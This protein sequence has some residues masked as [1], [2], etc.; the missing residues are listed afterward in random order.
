MLK[1]SSLKTMLA[2]IG[3]AA[4]TI[5]GAET[6]L[7]D[8]DGTGPDQPVQVQMWDFAPGNVLAK[9]G[10]TAASA[11]V[12]SPFQALG[13][14]QLIGLFNNGNAITTTR[15]N[16]DYEITQVVRYGETVESNNDLNSNS[17]PEYATFRFNSDPTVDNFFELW[18]SA[19]DA[20]ALAGTG[21]NNGTLILRGKVVNSYSS[22]FIVESTVPVLGGTPGD[23]DSSPDGNQYPGIKTVSGAG[24]TDPLTIQITYFNP[25]FFPNL[26]AGN[27][28]SF[29]VKV[30]NFSQGL[31]FI[32]TNPSGLF[33]GAPNGAAPNITPLI[34]ALNGISGPDVQF[35]TDFNAVIETIA[36]SDQSCRMTGGGV[37]VNHEMPLDENGF[38]LLLNA[39]AGSANGDRYEFGG[40]IGAPTAAQPQ[41]FGEWTHHQQS[42]PDGDF[43]FHAGTHSAPDATKIL[44]VA[45]VDPGYCQPARPAPFKQL[46]WEG[47]GQFN[48]VKNPPKSFKNVVVAGVSLHWVRVHYEDLGEPGGPNGAQTKN[49]SCTHVIGTIVG[50]PAT[51]SSAAATCSGCPDVYQITIYSKS[52]DPAVDKSN[53]AIYAVGGYIDHGN[54]QLHP[55]IN[56]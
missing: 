42:G 20:D 37:T 33:T 4:W 36:R 17:F 46:S 19:K 32:S 5:A 38:P 47:I 48:N 23:F 11:G 31:P 27:L 49:S 39:Q 51:S 41:P 6:V 35:Q 43:V 45:C 22:F 16:V 50:D 25:D 12:G 40:Q 15:L 52:T 54:I 21:Y 2:V 30:Q 53:K 34:G 24:N 8:P 44:R 55:A 9:D 7:F 10:V 18:W 13:H 1:I 56:P 29:L 28:I 3:C 14:S 26:Q